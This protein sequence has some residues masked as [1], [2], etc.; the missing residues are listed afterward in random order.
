MPNL[1][2]PKIPDGERL[3][4]DVSA[5]KSSTVVLLRPAAP[6]GLHHCEHSHHLHFCLVQD[7]H[8]KRME[9]DLNELQ[10]LIE[11][12]FES[13]KKEEEEL[14]SLKD[15]I[16][17]GQPIPFMGKQHRHSLQQQDPRCPMSLPENDWDLS[18]IWCPGVGNL[19]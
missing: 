15:R 14:I 9:K 13:R 19:L 16:V 17:R 12:H 18:Q 7:I 5:S 4:F 6:R 10:A 8:R 1:V 3:D 11:A 2:P